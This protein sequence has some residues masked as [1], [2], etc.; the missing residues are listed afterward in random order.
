MADR[1]RILRWVAQEAERLTLHCRCGEVVTLAANLAGARGR[2]PACD[3][4]LRAP[5]SRRG[6]QGESTHPM[7]EV[8]VAMMEPNFAPSGSGF[9]SAQLHTF[10]IGLFYVGAWGLLLSGLGKPTASF[11]G[12]IGF[13]PDTPPWVVRLWVLGAVI[14]GAC[15]AVPVAATYRRFRGR[16]Y[17][18]DRKGYAEAGCFDITRWTPLLVYLATLLVLLAI[19]PAPAWQAVR[20]PWRILLFAVGL[21]WLASWLLTRRVLRSRFGTPRRQP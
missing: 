3:R 8:K 19:G 7:K 17:A 10:V 11:L 6:S 12:A 14:G 9:Y 13:A 1:E 18:D 2:C 16:S 20:D 15:S 21:S 5:R 4:W